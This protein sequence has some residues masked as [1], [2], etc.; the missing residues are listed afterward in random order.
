MNKKAMALFGLVAAVAV[1]GFSVSGTYARYVSQIDL[2]DEARVAKWDFYTT[3][4][5]DCTSEIVDGNVTK[6]TCNRTEKLDLFGSSY[7]LLGNGEGDVYVKAINS[8]AIPDNVVAPGTEGFY[9][10]NFGGAM[11]VR[12]DFK[13]KFSADKDIEVYYY[14]NG[15]E[16]EI[17][18]DKSKKDATGWKIYSPIVYSINLFEGNNQL[19]YAEGTLKEVGAALDDW[20]SSAVYAPGRLG[21]SLQISW[22]WNAT[23]TVTSLSPDE[24]NELDTYLGKNWSKIYDLRD[25]DGKG[26]DLGDKAIYTLAVSATQITANG[27]VNS[28]P[29]VD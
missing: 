24:V 18:M 1:T 14:K 9:Q 17:S 3:D 25:E 27:D 5:K 11:E 6:W 10:V 22:K 2:T 13:I 28:K 21:L 29:D 8:E 15:D 12:H 7:T 16:F 19:K 26:N 20:S 4:T 23:N